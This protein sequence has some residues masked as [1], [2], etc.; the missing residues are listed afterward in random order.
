M[1]PADFTTFF[2]A[3]AG[4]GAALIGLLFVAVSI[5]PERTLHDGAPAERQA[6]ATSAFTALVNA[7][8]ISL[9][10]L[11]DIGTSIHASAVITTAVYV[12][13]IVALYDTI[14]VGL[15]LR[16]VPKGVLHVVRRVSLVIG[17]LFLYGSE[18]YI[19]VQLDR[20]PADPHPLYGL[21]QV[22]LLVYALGLLRAWELLGAR[23][24]GLVGWLSPLRDLD[25]AVHSAPVTRDA[26]PARAPGRPRMIASLGRT[27]RSH[28]GVTDADYHAA[29]RDV[30]YPGVH[31]D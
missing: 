31:R 2:L 13:G 15:I 6:L 9:A 22:L 3:S 16:H 20:L 17:G 7:F 25:E 4:A 10:A 27:R 28:E 1:L 19:G 24:H 5:S 12:L 8:F 29:H 18:V 23:R 11:L 26:A 21:G 14:R 30:A